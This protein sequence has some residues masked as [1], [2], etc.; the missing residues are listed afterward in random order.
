MSD[1]PTTLVP[2]PIDA[3]LAHTL[4][5]TPLGTQAGAIISRLIRAQLLPNDASTS[6]ITAIGRLKVHAHGAG[7]TDALLDEE[8]TFYNA[9]HRS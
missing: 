4:N 5:A 3:D 2:L 1:H 9:E 7:L 8:L 6:L